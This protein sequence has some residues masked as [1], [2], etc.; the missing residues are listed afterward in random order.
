MCP[1]AG[2][3]TDGW[4]HEGTVPNPVTLTY[5]TVPQLEIQG[6]IGEKRIRAKNRNPLLARNRQNCQTR[7]ALKKSHGKSENTLSNPI[8]NVCGRQPSSR[9]VWLKS[10]FS[11]SS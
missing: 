2:F 5:R 9:P 7:I 3:G 8:A 1:L 11:L 6:K 10:V 4:S